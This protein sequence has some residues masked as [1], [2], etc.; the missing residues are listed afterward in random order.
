MLTA[1]CA[2]DGTMLES[3]CP[4]ALSWYNLHMNGVDMADQNRTQ[5]FAILQPHV[6]EHICVKSSYR[7]L[8]FCGI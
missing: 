7:F 1:A 4:A 8:K 5:P 6:Y 3:E 2:N